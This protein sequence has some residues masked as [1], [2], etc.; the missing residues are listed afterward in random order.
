MILKP[1]GLHWSGKGSC[2]GGGAGSDRPSG[3][4]PPRISFCPFSLLINF[5][6]NIFFPKSKVN[7]IA[8][9]KEFQFERHFPSVR[10]VA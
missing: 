10:K 4:D 2:V 5:R 6:L 1:I 3:H 9:S 8:D 7:T